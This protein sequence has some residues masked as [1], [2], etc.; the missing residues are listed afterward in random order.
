V[1]CSLQGVE[2]TGT[3][4][5]A[6]PG[7]L[8]AIDRGSGRGATGASTGGRGALVLLLV[9]AT[10]AL[11][12]PIVLDRRSEF[13]AS[14]DEVAWH[15][16]QIERITA[17]FPRIDPDT[18]IVP[19]FPGYHWTMASVRWLTGFGVEA[20]RVLQLAIGVALVLVTARLLRARTDSSTATLLALV[21]GLAP[22][23]FAGSVRLTTDVPCMLMSVMALLE[24]S[25]PRSTR[26]LARSA[27]FTLAAILVRQTAVWIVPLLALRAFGRAGG[28]SR[29]WLWLL[30]PLGGLVAIFAKWGGVLPAHMSHVHVGFPNSHGVVIGLAVLG[31]YVIPTLP[32]IQLKARR[33]GAS[34]G[35]GAVVV[36]LLLAASPLA[37]EVFPGGGLWSITSRG[38]F[39]GELPFGLIALAS[40]GGA[41]L[42]FNLRDRAGVGDVLAFSAFLGVALVQ[43][44]VYERYFE[45]GALLFV[46]WTLP[47]WAKSSRAPKTFAT[48][49]CLAFLPLVALAWWTSP[50]E[51]PSSTE[52]SI[53]SEVSDR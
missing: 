47:R 21:L 32:F 29:A 19:M 22:T 15:Y 24:L 52:F 11:A 51:L 2:A 37:P 4:K 31:A 20:L 28:G 17:D 34:L 40:I 16:P 30:V 8:T 26:T 48:L 33:V 39:L 49:M 6:T 10:L 42:A 45:P 14:Y 50:K 38:P 46:L 43:A 25:R 41:Y 12:V 44:R 7:D 27:V 36:A 35:I 9:V 13:L 23:V 1:D 53:T 3:G 5:P 18:V